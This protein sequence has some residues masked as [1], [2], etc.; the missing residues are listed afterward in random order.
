[1]KSNELDIYE[2][3]L[4]SVRQL[5]S[6][7]ASINPRVNDLEDQQ[8]IDHFIPY[9]PNSSTY[10][11]HFQ[12][13]QVSDTS[14]RV[15]A[16]IWTRWVKNTRTSKL[17]TVDGGGTSEDY[18][19]VVTISSITAT[20]YIILTLNDTY[21]PSTCVASWTATYPTNTTGVIWVLGKVTC[22]SSVIT[23]IEQYWYGG[24]PGQFFMVPD[25]YSLSYRT[26][27]QL[28]IDGWMVAES[29]A[30][31]T[32]SLFHYRGADLASKYSDI[33][34]LVA[35]MLDYEGDQ[36]SAWADAWA[37]GKAD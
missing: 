11:Y 10:R 7:F 37:N 4:K 16:G 15:R 17:L 9:Q 36:F 24:D 35:S 18:D 34:D 3:I 33:D 12:I 32:S 19:D 6:Q 1:M 14:V 30:P 22:T 27:G 25:D 31:D 13:E 2:N 29:T 26:F 28:E 8:C 23:E 5:Q 20:G 21:E